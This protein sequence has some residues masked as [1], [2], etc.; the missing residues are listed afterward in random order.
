[1]WCSVHTLC[2]TVSAHA[3]TLCFHTLASLGLAHWAF[4]AVAAPSIMHWSRL[5]VCW[6]LLSIYRSQ[7]SSLRLW[8]WRAGRHHGHN[9]LLLPL[10]GHSYQLLYSLLRGCS[11][12]DVSKQGFYVQVQTRRPLFA[13][14]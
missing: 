2:Q 3:S 10:A 5:L 1:M 12:F 4:G 11:D 6:L 13:H 8:F 14:P 9:A 7:A